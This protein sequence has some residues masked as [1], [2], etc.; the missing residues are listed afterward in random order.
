MILAAAIVWA[1]GTVLLRKWQPPMPQ[2]TLSG[3][4]ML[5]GWLP[6]ALLAPLFDPQP[7]ARRAREPVARAA[8]SRSLYNIFL[9]GTARALGVVH[10]RAHA[11]G[12]R[13]VAV[14]AAGAGRRRV[15]RH[16]AARRAPGRRRNGSRSRWSS[17]RSFTV[18]FQ[19]PRRRVTA[20]PLAPDD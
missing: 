3:W 20:A 19:P 10:A 4:M 8:G 16:R 15:L 12:R 6:L 18:L 9:A 7:L 17:P 1:L 2:N 5:L 13:V 14:V 11:A